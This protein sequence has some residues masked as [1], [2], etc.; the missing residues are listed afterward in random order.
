MPGGLL[1]T[2]AL[3]RVLPWAEQ[4]MHALAEMKS[5]LAGFEREPRGVVRVAVLPGISRFLMAPALPRL[6]ARHPGL[7]IELLPA[8]AVVDLTRR[9]ADLAIRTVRPETGDLVVQR[10]AAFRIALMAAPSLL[11]GRRRPALSRLPWLDFAEDMSGTPESAWLRAQVPGARVVLRSPD[12]E[13]LISAAQSGLGALAVAQ[14]LGRAAG[15]LVELPASAPPEGT[16]WLV[17]HR[18]VRNVPRVSVVWDWAV[19]TFA[20]AAVRAGKD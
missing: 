18:A 19:R 3:E 2:P 13:T 20:E 12:L 6:V 1:P 7:S 8:S 4:A 14:P 10:L 17:A 15:G 16:L 9:E 11:A 5:E